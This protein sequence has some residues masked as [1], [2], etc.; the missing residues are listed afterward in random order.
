V[1]NLVV[2][3]AMHT[4]RL[5]ACIC[6]ICGLGPCFPNLQ[7]R[8]LDWLAFIYLGKDYCVADLEVFLLVL[9]LLCT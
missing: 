2:S 5:E 9:L 1:K 8:F 4:L 3:R 6:E 7:L